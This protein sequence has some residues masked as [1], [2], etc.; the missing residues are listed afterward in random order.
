MTA[1]AALPP[2][3]RRPKPR[4][5]IRPLPAPAPPDSREGPP[6]AV[7]PLRNGDRLNAA[8]FLRRYEATDA[9]ESAEL[10]AGRVY[11][12][13]MPVRQRAHSLPHSLLGTWAGNYHAATPGTE[14]GDNGTCRL[15][16]EDVPQPDVFLRLLAEC[17][18]NTYVDDADYIVGGPELVCEVAAS[19]VAYDLHDKLD[20]YR[21]H[22]VREYLVWRTEDAAVDWFALRG[23]GDDAVYEPLPVGDDGIIR[24][25]VLP[26]LRLDPAALLRRDLAGVLARL[27]DGLASDE[28][29]AFAAGLAAKLAEE[30]R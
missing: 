28:H 25:E 14:P 30:G 24:S 22:G 16:E 5:A 19:S 26:G 21:A 9:L 13:V 27:N 4:S 10:I 12:D 29:A 2:P 20:A 6:P 17:G 11:L 8:E 7:P 3:A 1:P 23:A 15:S 18:G